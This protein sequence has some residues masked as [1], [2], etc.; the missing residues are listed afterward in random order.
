MRVM[1]DTTYSQR[2]PLSG[3][4]VY[5]ERLCAELPRVPGSEIEVVPVANAR[6]RAPAGGGVGSARNLANDVAWTVAELPRLA[7]RKRAD[8]IHHPLPALSP[9]ARVPQVVTVADLAFERL[10]DQFDRAFRTYAHVTHRAAARRA[11]AVICV[12]ETTAADAIELWGLAPE[13]IVVAPHG[14]GQEL[15]PARRRRADDRRPGRPTPG[16]GRPEPWLRSRRVRS[17]RGP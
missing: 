8:V 16:S 1:I 3:T 13:R 10:P 15:A 6:R 11:P 12:S 4:A 14:P 7:R 9:L 17:R 5:I 2:A